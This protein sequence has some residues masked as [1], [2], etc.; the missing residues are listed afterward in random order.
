MSD[1]TPG[2]QTLSGSPNHGCFHDPT[3]PTSQH[4]ADLPLSQWEES[5]GRLINSG[6]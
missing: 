2:S 3:A 6:I 1:L 4:D 5:N